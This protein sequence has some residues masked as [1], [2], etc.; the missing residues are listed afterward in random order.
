LL[1]SGF[2]ELTRY[3]ARTALVSTGIP[4]RAGGRSKTA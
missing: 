3:W 2:E 1:S 4:R